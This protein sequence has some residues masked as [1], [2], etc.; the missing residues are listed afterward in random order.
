MIDGVFAF[1]L[2]DQT[3]KKAFVARDPYG[4]RPLFK[5]V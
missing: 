4:V 3:L 2:I 5:H 1:V